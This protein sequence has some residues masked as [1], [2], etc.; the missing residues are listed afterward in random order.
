MGGS[1]VVRVVES[2]FAGDFNCFRLVVE[3]ECR[4]NG[5]KQ[6]LGARLLEKCHQE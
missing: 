1:F 4:D 5:I 3:S 6:V 2:Y